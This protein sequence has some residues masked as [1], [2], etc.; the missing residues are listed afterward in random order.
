MMRFILIALAATTL[1][2][3]GLSVPRPAV[4][5]SVDTFIEKLGKPPKTRSGATRVVAAGRMET[6]EIR[7]RFGSA[8]LDDVGRTNAMNLAK[9]MQDPRFGNGGV[10]IIGH[11]DAV[12]SDGDNLILSLRRAQ[13]V[14]DFLIQNGVTPDRI[15]AQGRGE[16]QLAMPE[17]PENEAN[18]RVE[19][20]PV[21]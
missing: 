21:Y 8:E 16:Q 13:T 4:A 15:E 2:A 17:D 19:L 10:R 1:A 6:R 7:F 9:A 5:Q 11:T 20:I 12:G 14:R 18:R 3:A